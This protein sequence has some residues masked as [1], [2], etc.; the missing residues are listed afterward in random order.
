MIENPVRLSVLFT[1]LLLAMNSSCEIVAKEASPPDWLPETTVAYLSVESAESLLDHPVRRQIQQT[2]VFKQLW[3]RPEL[4]QFR[5]GLTVVEFALGEQIETLLKRVNHGGMHI[6]F[7]PASKGVVL[8]TKTE[9]AEWLAEYLNK[10]KTMARNDAQSKSQPDPIQEREYRN[11]AGTK[12]HEAIVAPLGPWLLVAN[13]PELAK[14]IIDRYV[15]Q[16]PDSLVSNPL[17]QECQKI[18]KTGSHHPASVRRLATLFVDLDALRKAEMAK[19]ILGKKR[20]DFGAELVLG[21]V[22]ASLQHAHYGYVELGMDS[23][24]AQLTASVPFDLS[25]VAESRQ[26]YVGPDAKGL[27]PSLLK[28]PDSI[29]SISAYRN[30]SQLWLRAGDLFDQQ[31]NEQLAQADNTLTTLFSG[32]DFGGDILGAIEPELQLLV[33]K[34][35]FNTSEISPSLKLPS[36]ALIGQLKDPIKMKRELKRIFQ[37]VIGFFNIVGA[38]DGQPQLELMSEPKE[39]RDSEYYWAEYLLDSDKSYAN[40]LPIQFNFKPCI[41]F[42]GSR[43]VVASTMDIAKQVLEGKKSIEDLPAEIRG[44]TDIVLELESL[45]SILAANRETLITNNVLEKG[46]TRQNAEKEIDLLLAIMNLGKEIRGSL[47]FDQNASLSLQLLLKAE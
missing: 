14:S 21:G 38:M 4:K 20:K 8:F 10:L 41:A 23:N 27:A 31:V 5:L 34:Q 16:T 18:Q 33:A 26:F 12:F 30:L 35:N 3:S 37:S 25:A 2:Q 29:A 19:D 46:H 1:I 11:I 17:F 13:K 9:S 32:K 47:R 15:D 39:Q 36:I 43:V 24:G 40:G 7:D 22:L 6:A 42:Q 44:N 28:L 45:R